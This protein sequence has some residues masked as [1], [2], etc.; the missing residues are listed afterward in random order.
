MCSDFADS[1]VKFVREALTEAGCPVADKFF[2]PER[3]SIQAGGGFKQD[4]G[5]KSLHCNCG[6]GRLTSS[7]IHL[8]AYKL[9]FAYSFDQKS[10]KCNRY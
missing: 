4:E 3:C 5:V 1:T 9:L 8:A 10:F 2:K 7:S 6:F